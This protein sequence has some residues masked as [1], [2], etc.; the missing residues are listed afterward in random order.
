MKTFRIVVAFILT[1]CPAPTP[2]PVTPPP[3]AVVTSFTVDPKMAA[4]GGMVTLT[5][6]TTDAKRTT[7]EHVGVGPVT[8]DP[9]A[10]SGTVQVAV[11]A[12]STFVLTAQ[13]EGGTDSAVQSVKLLG[14]MGGF[15][16]TAT[17]ATLQ[18]GQSTTLL[19]SVPGESAVSIAPT[20]GA[21]LDLRG[22][23]ASGSITVTPASSTR[24]TLTAGA[25]TATLDVTVAP[26]IIEF[27]AGPSPQ[28]G[29]MFSLS[30]KTAGGARV[31]LRRD[32]TAA[33]IFTEMD[34]V[35]VAEGS[36]QDTVP[37]GLAADTVLT[38]RLE[39]EQGA[40]K[41]ESSAVVR[42]GGAL[43]LL[44]FTAPRYVRVGF[45]F[46]V[47]WSTRGATQVQLEADDR[48]VYVA[49]NAAAA[50]S[51]SATLAGI[52]AGTQRLRIVVRNDRG[53]FVSEER[54]VTAVGQPTFNS[55]TADTATIA[56]GGNPVVLSWNVTN[57]RDIRITQAGVGLVH[58]AT[59]VLDTGSVT[60]FPNRATSTFTLLASNGAGDSVT[61]MNVT[62]TVT[63]PAVLTF[64]RP[65]PV[66]ATGR[67]TGHTVVGGAELFGL[68]SVVKNA[69][70]EQFIDISAT[71][72][73]TNHSTDVTAGLNALGETFDTRIFGRRISAR[74][75]SISP[76][77]WFYFADTAFSGPATPVT[78]LA[79]TQPLA[80]V[81]YYQD[82]FITVGIGEVF[83]RLD[84][85]GAD[86]RLIVQWNDVEDFNTD[87]SRITFQAQVYSSGKVVFAY[88]KA[89]GLPA[90]F[91]PMH[92]IVNGSKDAVLAFASM[93]QPGDTLT[94]FG[95]SL[96]PQDVRIED[97]PYVARVAV[98]AGYI[99]VEGDG[100]LLAG[101]F[102][103]TEVNPR[104][105]V[106]LTNAE[107]IEVTNFSSSLIDLNGMTLDFGGGNTHV[108]GSSVQIAPNSVAIL[109]Q[110]ADLGD[111][112]AALNARYVYPATLAMSD[113]SGSVTL[114]VNGQPYSTASWSSPA[115]GV[116]VR[117]DRPVH[118]ARYVTVGV[119]PNCSGAM[120]GTYG[121][122]TGTPG[123]Q[124]AQCV[125]FPYRLSQLPQSNFES[126]AA[127]GVQIDPGSDSTISTV[128]LPNPIRYFGMSYSAITLSSNG[129]ISTSAFTAAT[130]TNKSG[131]T[132]SAPTG[133]I[134]PFW[135]DLT[136][137]AG[138][139]VG[140]YRAERDPDMT[141]MTGDEYTIISW[142]GYR[143]GTGQNLN[144]QVK[145]FANGNIEYHFGQMGAGSS[146][147][148]HLGSGA[149]TWLEDP[150]G[151]IALAVSVNAVAAGTRSN[152]AFRFTYVP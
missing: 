7:L 121:V 88:Q 135:D 99:E 122:Q 41:V 111:P 137:T 67:V 29:T 126:I 12:D 54:T 21:P 42:I 23:A 91:T 71:G 3:P 50:A 112:T 39:L 133:S 72:S 64:E 18:P 19:W 66:G 152:T 110:A 106:G 9:A 134:A 130:T 107:W 28:P 140:C 119:P 127:T 136:A 78:V 92:G 32:G 96:L 55:F 58:A 26:T 84:T 142:E 6:A 35:R 47:S 141:P 43:Q 151:R 70:G 30:W 138:M 128:M 102:A 65:V 57:A 97:A 33:P 80:V 44:S 146:G 116:S 5:W 10:A 149:T 123:A 118:G 22:Q 24:Y 1:A 61:P 95:S 83:M 117:S 150:T 69:P 109:A 76:D 85:V 81:P 124:H 17:P 2:E 46:S 143:V 114:R 38:Y 27:R 75:I 20:G 37:M 93:P 108:I 74:N 89:T 31:V 73:P 51:G 87:T 148:T 13:G 105:A 59:G 82:L 16:F 15:I 94:F 101:S 147:L 48:P 36:F 53:G 40:A 63:T 129:V 14:G 100:R 4:S 113:T 8:I 125:A 68:P 115:A 62:V 120:T 34:P 90:G 49:P 11:T 103:I 77:G 79:D 144:F 104:P 98:G 139:G 56:A 131:P 60:V 132:T 145:F 52:P 86:R 25:R 45:P